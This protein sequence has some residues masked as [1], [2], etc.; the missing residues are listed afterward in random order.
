MQLHAS[1]DSD[2]VYW[3]LEDQRNAARDMQWKK[4]VNSKSYIENANFMNFKIAF[5]LVVVNTND[6]FE[7]S[8]VT[9]TRGYRYKL[10]KKSNNRNIR[11]TFFLWACNQY[12]EQ[13]PCW[14]RFLF[15]K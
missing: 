7:F 15:T 4:P 2:V 9:Q 13:T 1:R 12:M 8:T 3:G 10:F 5:G 6:L 14:Y 11:T